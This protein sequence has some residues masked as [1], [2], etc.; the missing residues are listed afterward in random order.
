MI[1]GSRRILRLAAALMMTVAA[2]GC[3]DAF[4]DALPKIEVLMR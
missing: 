2:A 1:P 4:F 3:V